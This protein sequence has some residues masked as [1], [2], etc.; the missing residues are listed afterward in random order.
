MVGKILSLVLILMLLTCG[1]GRAFPGFLDQ[2]ITKWVDSPGY[3]TKSS[4]MVARGLT[5]IA[6][7]PYELAY[8]WFDGAMDS[9]PCGMGF[10][11]GMGIGLFWMTD[12]M[13]RGAW[14]VLSAPW[15]GYR[16]APGSHDDSL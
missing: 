12:K 11:K 10:F 9:H 13:A 8:H 6:V 7:S 1:Q 3:F 2:K 15:P 16:G 5:A 14:D 4:G